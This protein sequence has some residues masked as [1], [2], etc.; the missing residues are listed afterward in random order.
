M[1]RTIKTTFNK[2]IFSKL[3]YIDPRTNEL[4]Q[5]FCP[6]PLKGFDYYSISPPEE[7]SKHLRNNPGESIVTPS[8]EFDILGSDPEYDLEYGKLYL[9]YYINSHGY[10]EIYLPNNSIA[11]YPCTWFDH[12]KTINRRAYYDSVELLNSPHRYI[13]KIIK[14]FS[15]FDEDCPIGNNVPENLVGKL[16]IPLWSDKDSGHYISENFSIPLHCAKNIEGIVN[17]NGY[18]EFSEDDDEFYHDICEIDNQGYYDLVNEEFFNRNNIVD[19]SI[20][21]NK[22]CR[23]IQW[24]DTCI[25]VEVSGFHGYYCCNSNHL[26]EI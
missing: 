4:V 9:S 2:E 20:L 26:G 1:R 10:M 24:F 7:W 3:F 15:A 14:S 18:I 19:K 5:N 16:F 13:Y 17:D 11:T 6:Q 12:V 21:L 25:K 8:K 22:P 23:I